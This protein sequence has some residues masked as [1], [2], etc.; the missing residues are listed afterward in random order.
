MNRNG[1]GRVAPFILSLLLVSCSTFDRGAGYQTRISQADYTRE[2]F[3]D[4]T[5]KGDYQEAF[6]LYHSLFPMGKSDPDWVSLYK[7]I[8]LGLEESLTNARDNRNLTE[9]LTISHSMAVVDGKPKSDQLTFD[10]LLFLLERGYSAAAA[11]QFLLDPPVGLKKEQWAELRDFF[12]DNN[13]WGAVKKIDEISPS[14]EGNVQ[15]GAKA[16]KEDM[17]RGTVTVWVNKGIRLE[18]GIGLPDRVIGSGFFIDP[19]GYILTNYH[20]ISSE[21]DPAYEGY[22]R[23][24]IKLNHGGDE[25]IPA[26]VVGWDPVLDLALIKAEISSPYVFPLS[27]EDQVALGDSIFAIGSPGGLTNSVTTGTISNLERNL[28]AMGVSLQIDVPINPGN[29]GGPLLN[30]KGEVIGVVYAGIEEYEGVNFAI[31]S[32]YLKIVLP[33]LYQGGK[34]TYSWLGGVVYRDFN[35]LVN[36][37]SIPDTPVSLAGLADDDTILSVNGVPVEK[38]HQIQHVLMNTY[39]GELVR[40]QVGRDGTEKTLY[41]VTAERPDYPMEALLDR[42]SIDRLFAPLFGMKTVRVNTNRTTR[43]YRIS[44]V[45]PG[46]M[47]DETG[48]V[49]GDS[50]TLRKWVDN[51]EEKI[52]LIQIIIKARKSGFLE[53][54][55]QM[56]TW[57]GMNYF[58]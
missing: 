31:P 52:L 13:Q 12:A 9:A 6:T 53:S 44:H 15:S 28:Q 45:F 46:S 50:F 29:S 1:L 7:D 18:N 37:Y 4:L 49:P 20:V 54:G 41:A 30:Q 35:K 47:A 10:Y 32:Y 19:N 38:I 2:Y 17:L 40:L 3:T 5:A 57:Y 39:P 36:R 56:G 24:Y 8:R 25:K 22:S 21:V 33:R 11:G 26:R 43:Q 34:V 14:G 48:L 42:D 55:L 51:R 16:S 23:L 58:Y 27:G